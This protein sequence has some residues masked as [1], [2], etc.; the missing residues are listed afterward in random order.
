MRKIQ[1]GFTLIEMLVALVIFALM[2]VMAYRGL[3]T[4]LESRDHLAQENRKWR[5]VALLFARLEQDFAVL[6]KRPVR[7]ANDLRAEPFV[8]KPEILGEDDAMLMFTRMGLSGQASPLAGP[9]R[10]GYR[11]RGNAIEQLVWPAPDAAPRTIPSVN[12]LLERVA[13]AEFRYFDR[14]GKWQVRWPLPGGNMVYPAAVEV[15]IELQSGERVTR[16]F[17]LPVLQ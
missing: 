5:E 15:A 9:Q 7:D 6:A 13:A 17:A 11:L 4:V 3:T 10:F 2:S 16:L 8:A 12:T 1:S 14:E